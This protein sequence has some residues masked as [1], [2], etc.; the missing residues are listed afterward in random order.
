MEAIFQIL[1]EKPAVRA[2]DIAE[3]LRVR[4][5]SVTG[6]LRVLC[7]DGLINHAPYD[8]VTLTERG[9]TVAGE[10]VRRH[11]AIKTFL[12]DVLGVEE[13]E[14]EATACGLEHVVSPGA[15]TRLAALTVG[16]KERPALLAALRSGL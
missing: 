4:R 6:A 3:R 13:E 12:A 10:I 9:R 8:V 15:A 16:L 1:R 7:R 11:E 14:A 5:P 2:K